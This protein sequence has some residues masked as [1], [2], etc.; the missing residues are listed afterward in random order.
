MNYYSILCLA[1]L[2]T[3][4]PG[5]DE[6]VIFQ[7][8]KTEVR[9]IQEKYEVRL[10]F[11]ILDGYYIQAEEDV[12][13]NIIATRV[14][15]QEDKSHEIISYE[16]ASK[17]EKTIYLDTIAH[18]VLSDELVL[19]V[20]IK[21]KPGKFQQDGKLRGELVYQA[22]NNRQCFYPRSLNFEVEFI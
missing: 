6:F 17:K 4:L 11:M 19:L 1:I 18:A 3:I 7:P 14:S 12:P 10:S 20:T 16:I 22:C 15:F 21:P 13:E 9:K 2:F 8:E 5:Q